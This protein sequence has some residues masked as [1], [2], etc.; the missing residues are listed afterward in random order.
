[1]A[2]T[3]LITMSEYPIALEWTISKDRLKAFLPSNKAGYIKSDIFTAVLAS[4]V[5]FYLDIYPSGYDDIRG[6]T[7]IFLNFNL[8]KEAK[9]E[10]EWTFSIE[11]AGWKYKL[12]HI[13][14]TNAGFG[15]TVCG[16]GELFDLNKK[17]IVDGKLIVK[18]EGICKVENVESKWKTSKDFGDLWNMDSKDLTV[19]ADGNTFKVHKC[20][21]AY[22]SILAE[23]VHQSNDKGESKIEFTD[24]PLE[25]VE[26]AVKLCYHRNLVP[27]F[28]V[29]EGILL[30]KFADKY[31]VI[32]LKVHTF[33]LVTVIFTHILVLQEN[34]EGFLTDRLNVT[35]E[36]LE[37]FL[38]DR[39]NV[40]NVCEIL[41]AAI[42]S[43]ST[44]LQH[45]CH[46]FIMSTFLKKKYM[47][48]M[49]ILDKTVLLTILNNLS[50]YES[51]TL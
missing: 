45:K 48:K 26:K 42:T 32:D 13:Y 28:T 50:F 19:V 36:N 2:S 22:H 25:I 46:D 49:E 47:P 3:P 44:I 7:M 39:L 31:S 5:Q 18:V 15:V 4:D 17:F 21:L 14:E 40:T 33:Y 8:G 9:L 38:T 37:G 24:F 35:N 16:V 12:D 43:N 20:V 1:M 34:L 23:M 10:G 6:Q 30:F 51:V 27:S 41:D 11:S 29:D